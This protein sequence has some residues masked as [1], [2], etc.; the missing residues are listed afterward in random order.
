MPKLKT[1]KTAMKRF[2]ST[3]TGKIRRGNTGMNHLKMAKCAAAKRRLSMKSSV[4]KG[5]AKVIRKMVPNV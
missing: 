1:S 4:S 2:E 5:E 3:G